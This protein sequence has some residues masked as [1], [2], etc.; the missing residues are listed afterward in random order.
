VLLLVQ[1]GPPLPLLR[2]P[3]CCASCGALCAGLTLLLLLAAALAVLLLPLL[4][5]LPAPLLL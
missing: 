5:W 4:L 2:L 3:R 1:L